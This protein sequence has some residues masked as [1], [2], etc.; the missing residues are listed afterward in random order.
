MNIT[1]FLLARISEEE[2]LAQDA[3]D[4]DSGQDGGFED[5][6]D[7]LTGSGP[8]GHVPAFGDA[9]AR[10]VVWNTPRRM[11]AECAA[12]RA[13]VKQHEDWPV[14][15]EREP[16]ITSDFQSM[17]FRMSH[18]MAWLTEREYINRFGIEPPTAPM[19]R[20]LASVYKD[21]PDYDPE[22]AGNGDR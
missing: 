12:K 3:I 13:I 10:L 2:R 16:T 21:H 14:L 7:S 9:A 19:I 18:E 5:S 11:L 22:W 8:L 1:D 20:T 15:V 4:D 17:T 6:F